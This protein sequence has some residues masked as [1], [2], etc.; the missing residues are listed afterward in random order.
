LSRILG[1][2]YGEKR[3]GLA[4]TDPLNIIA[5]PLQ[6]INVSKEDIYKV[7]NQLIK[8]YQ[9]VKIV[10]GLP[11]TLKNTHS[12]QTDKVLVFIQQLKNNI[13]IDI[14]TYDERFTSDMAKDALIKQGI[15]TGHNKSEIDKTAAAIFLQNYIDAK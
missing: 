7:L 6:T 13:N 11:L 2:D 9:I 4:I 14:D 10:V 12:I 15:K 5:K 8:E 3:I 1:L